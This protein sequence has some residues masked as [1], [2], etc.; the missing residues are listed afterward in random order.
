MS[1]DQ[2]DFRNHLYNEMYELAS[3]ELKSK[4][5]LVDFNPGQILIHQHQIA[6]LVL[7]PQ[8]GLVSSFKLLG[9]KRIE[10]HQVGCEGVLGV[11]S[12]LFTDGMKEVSTS[13]A[14][15]K[16]SALG[17]ATAAMHTLIADFP[18]I[19]D[20]IYRYQIEQ[21][22]E[23]LEVLTRQAACTVTER[24]PFWLVRADLRLGGRPLHITHETLAGIHCVRRPT[25]TKSLHNL[26]GLGAIKSLPRQ[27][28]VRNRP[29]LM[30][31]AFIHI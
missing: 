3:E 29:L 23:T 11:P 5:T 15:T 25:I 1:I 13:V 12:A 4:T 24:L 17:L 9:R 27:I 10:A 20:M 31:L 8:T 19:K 6:K 2:C 16:G 7:F 18:S 22:R 30:Q 26:E 21:N 14:Q 28:E